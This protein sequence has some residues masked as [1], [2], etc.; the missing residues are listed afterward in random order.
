M[1]KILIGFTGS[2]AST[3]YKKIITQFQELGE[4]GVVVTQAATKF[5]DVDY[6]KNELKVPVYTDADEW[7][8]KSTL[9]TKEDDVLH[10]KLKN[11]YNILVVCP[12][13]MNTI[14]KFTYGLADNLLTSLFAAWDRPH[15]PIIL[16][17]AMNTNMFLSYANSK[18]L[19]NMQEYNQVSFV[20]EPVE[21]MLACGDFGIGGLDDITNI[22]YKVKTFLKWRYPVNIDDKSIIPIGKHPGAFSALRKGSRHTGVDIYTENGELVYAVETGKVISIE[23]FT[24]KLD[25]SPWWED[26]YCMLLEG[27]SGV[28][29]YGEITPAFWIKP[30]DILQQGTFL[31]NVKR[32]IKAG[33][34][35]PDIPGHRPNMLHLELYNPGT[36]QASC[37]YENSI[38]KFLLD[39]TPYLLNARNAPTTHVDYD[40]Y[41]KEVLN[42][43]NYDT[44]K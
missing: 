1:H 23:P 31:G 19:Q 6:I 11:E 17:P 26:T 38:N 5:L 27:A 35:R 12:A 40:G 29:C 4:V 15:K 41:E 24:G 33:K 44:T 36:K 32:V 10:I 37:G 2:V 43:K 34:E 3:L 16:C 13:S 39:P 7:N 42:Y 28:V 21:K 8:F 30:N 9:W 22:C 25:N 18:N 14:S 20:I